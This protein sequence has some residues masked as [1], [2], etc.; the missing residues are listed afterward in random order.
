MKRLTAVLLVFIMA[1]TVLTG[2]GGKAKSKLSEMNELFTDL[3]NKYAK[4]VESCYYHDVYSKTD[5][6]A[7]FDEWK[8]AVSE[9]SDIVDKQ[10]LLTSDEMDSVIA[11]M[12]ELIPQFETIISQYEIPETT[13]AEKETTAAAK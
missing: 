5:I 2:C 6:A 9:C 12:Q 4:A 11:K 1:L 3:G 13:A 8:T 10:S 7:K